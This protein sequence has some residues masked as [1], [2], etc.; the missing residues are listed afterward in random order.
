MR[1]SSLRLCSAT[2]LSSRTRTSFLGDDAFV[3][4]KIINE[5]SLIGRLKEP[6]L[7]VLADMEQKVGT[8]GPHGFLRGERAVEKEVAAAGRGRK[9]AAK[10]HFLFSVFALAG[11]KSLHLSFV[12][13]GADHVDG[14][15][16]PENEID[17]LENEAFAGPGFTGQD[18]HAVA[19]FQLHVVDKG[20]VAY[21]QI[22]QH[23][24]TRK[25][26]CGQ[27]PMKHLSLKE[28]EKSRINLFCK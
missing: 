11:E 28:V 5:R 23:R 26:G 1:A 20:Q 10:H 24:S 9:F 8:K 25:R 22:F 27:G 18:V 17:G 19:E 21:A 4:Q 6:L 16:V 15:L 13:A 12:A 2:S 14:E 7:P 3:G